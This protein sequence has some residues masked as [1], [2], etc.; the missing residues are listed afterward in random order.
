M[1]RAAGRCA[2]CLARTTEPVFC[3]GA[4]A[5]NHAAFDRVLVPDVAIEVLDAVAE[6]AAATRTGVL[7]LW[8]QLLT[9]AIEQPAVRA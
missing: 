3:S 1:T 2:Y 9:A 8:D 4:C 6:H 5:Q 7:P